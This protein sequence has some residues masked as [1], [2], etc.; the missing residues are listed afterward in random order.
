MP[1]TCIRD[2]N[3]IVQGDQDHQSTMIDWKKRPKP[4]VSEEMSE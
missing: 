3:K 4:P 1:T 2:L